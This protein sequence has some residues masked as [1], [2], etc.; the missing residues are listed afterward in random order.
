MAVNTDG[1]RLVPDDNRA[2]SRADFLSPGSPGYCSHQPPTP[3]PLAS[4]V[5][6][7]S[8]EG[9]SPPLPHRLQDGKLSRQQWSSPGNGC[10]DLLCHPPAFLIKVHGDM[11]GEKTPVYAPG[12]RAEWREE[13]WV[14]GGRCKT[15]LAMKQH[16][17]SLF[18]SHRHSDCITAWLRE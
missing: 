11:S 7:W 10:R 13:S 12:D 16:V 17:T 1:V 2:R 5:W 8:T 3:A 15:A 4:K 14:L 6:V 18:M 9:A